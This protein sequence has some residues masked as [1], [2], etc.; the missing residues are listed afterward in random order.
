MSL[1]SH[2]AVPTLVRIMTPASQPNSADGIRE[3]FLQTYSR[4]EGALALFI[5]G[6]TVSLVRVTAIKGDS[7]GV[8]CK[9]ACVMTEG[10]GTLGADKA[11]CEL[12]AAWDCF[13]QSKAHWKAHYVNWQLFF[14]ALFITEIQRAAAELVREGKIMGYEQAREFTYEYWSRESARPLS[15]AEV[16]AL[17]YD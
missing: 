1:T 9:I 15:M 2:F 6:K 13:S 17:R 11:E 8:R 3:K 7:W 5:E 16:P 14:D 12:R 10:L 4:F